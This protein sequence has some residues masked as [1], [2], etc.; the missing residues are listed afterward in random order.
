MKHNTDCHSSMLSALSTPIILQGDGTHA[1]RDPAVLHHNG[2]FHLFCTL[3]ETDPDERIYS[4]TVQSTSRD[5]QQWTEP[6]IITPKGQDLNYSS[7]GNV[8]QQN[9]GAFSNRMASATPGHMT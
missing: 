7:P 1:Y 2:V 8:I 9:G 4:Y 6:T 5:L 3:V